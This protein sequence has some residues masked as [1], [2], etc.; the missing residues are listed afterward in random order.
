MT[1]AGRNR[2]KICG[3]YLRVE[4]QVMD[5]VSTCLI[6]NDLSVLDA[7]KNRFSENLHQSYIGKITVNGVSE[8][9]NF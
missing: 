8:I 9:L 7:D 4:L 6:R 3:E 1:T 5:A 2:V